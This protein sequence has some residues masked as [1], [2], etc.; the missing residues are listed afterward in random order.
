MKKQMNPAKRSLLIFSCTVLLLAGLTACTDFGII[1]GGENSS[2][3]TATEGDSSDEEVHE[4][5][6]EVDEDSGS[7]EAEF[8]YSFSD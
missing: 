4:F 1:T 7:G 6:V 2:Q 3:R 5:Q 8:G